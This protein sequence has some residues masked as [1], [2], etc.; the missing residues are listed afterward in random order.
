MAGSTVQ[1]PV[2]PMTGS[3]KKSARGFTAF[4]VLHD[5]DH[6]ARLLGRAEKARQHRVAAREHAD[7]ADSVD[8]VL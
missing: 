5:L 6:R 7:R 8:H 1:P 2:A 3:Q 4:T